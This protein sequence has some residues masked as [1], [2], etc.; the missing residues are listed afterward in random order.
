MHFLLQTNTPITA[1]PARI[2]NASWDFIDNKAT[3]TIRYY[4]SV[5]DF[6]A[7]VNGIQ[8]TYYQPLP[9][10]SI[11]NQIKDFITPAIQYDETTDFAVAPL[12]QEILD[13]LEASQNEPNS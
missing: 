4:T 12:P 3:I 2:V 13:A 11:A 10:M 5:N 6:V 1:L 8:K 9:D 7:D